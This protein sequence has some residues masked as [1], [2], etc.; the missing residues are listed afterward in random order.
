MANENNDTL[1]TSRSGNGVVGRRA[2]LGAASAG[3][4]TTTLAGCMG[5]VGGGGGDGTF[6]IGH[7]GPTELQMGR[8]AERSAELAVSE[9]NDNGGILDRDVELLSRDTGGAPSEGERVT[10]DLVQSEQVDLLVGTFVSEVTQGI[11]DFVAEMD[12]P[13]VITGSADPA[14]ITD[15]HGEDY[16]T[17]KNIVRTGPIN[18]DLQAEGMGGY[19]SY[20]NEQHGFENFSILADDA[21]WTGSFRDILPDEIESNDDLSVVHQDRMSVETSNF[22]PFLDAADEAD[23]DVVMRFIA[24]GGAAA[25][26]STWAQNEYPFALEGISVP[27]MSPE[28]WG[29]TE[30][31]CLYETT[32]QSGAGGVAE[33]TDRTKP[34]VDAYEEEFGGGDPP[35]KPMYMGFNSYDG[36][37]FYAQAAEDAGTADYESDLDGIVESMLDLEFTGAAGEISLYGEDADYPNDVRETRNDDDIISNFPVTQW[38]EDGD[39]GVVECVYPEPDATSEHVVPEWI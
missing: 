12:V 25:F 34:F 10:E 9:L 18:S 8:G 30:G 4:L 28:F 7:L 20:L 13:F 29:A 16:E 38:Q 15:N 1:E 2:F 21:A 3:A 35:S 14:T 32:S 36:I 22:N 19:A 37:L 31:A 27:G 11:I 6:K 26:T 39:G 17:Y 33:L 23:A 5:G 24:H